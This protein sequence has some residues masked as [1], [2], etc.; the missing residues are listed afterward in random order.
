MCIYV[1]FPDA[2]VTEKICEPTSSNKSLTMGKHAYLSF[3][4]HL[5]VHSHTAESKCR[6]TMSMI[7]FS[8]HIPVL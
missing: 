5:S 4:F 1:M 3:Y 7:S 2:V 8:P 6:N